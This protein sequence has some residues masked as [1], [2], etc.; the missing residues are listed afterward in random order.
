MSPG[1]KEG[2]LASELSIN[3]L[4]APTVTHASDVIVVA[5]AR[6]RALLWLLAAED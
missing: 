3:I 4:G 1:E 6:V 2:F 5:R